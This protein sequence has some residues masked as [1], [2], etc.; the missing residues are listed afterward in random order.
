[1]A[2]PTAN[3]AQTP[4]TGDATVTDAC[5]DIDDAPT[6]TALLLTAGAAG[7]VVDRVTAVPRATI[8]ATVVYLFASS[9]GGTTQRLINAKPAGAETISTTAAPTVI[10]FGYTRLAP[11]E[12]AANEH[13]YCAAS[14]ALAG[15]W[16]FRA[17]GADFA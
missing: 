11:L 15:G 10:D 4:I 7:A 1:M 12:L 3:F 5:T 9:D 16:C 14:V 2:T 6:D 13:L 17:E 8:A